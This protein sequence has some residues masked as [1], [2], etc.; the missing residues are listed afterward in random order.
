MCGSLLHCH[1]VCV[2]AYI[3]MQDDS[4][5]PHYQRSITLGDKM[6][7]DARALFL[8]HYRQQGVIAATLQ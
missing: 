6:H 8:P 3:D 4:A 5:C 1:C 2:C 7:P